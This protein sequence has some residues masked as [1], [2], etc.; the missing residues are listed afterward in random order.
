MKTIQ[1]FVVLIGI[2]VLISSCGP[3][4]G[5]DDLLS[6]SAWVLTN[7]NG[8][9]PLRESQPTISFESGDVNGS[10]GCNRFFGSYDASNNNLEFSG[11]GW[12]EMACLSPEGV[13]AQEQQFMKFLQETNQ[14]QI[15][16]D[17]LTLIHSSGRLSFMRQ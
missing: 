1:K 8:D 14:Y 3:L 15:N 13:M 9:P 16:G 11:L 4:F 5:Q 2:L 12:T 6:G 10:T 17:Q 7:L